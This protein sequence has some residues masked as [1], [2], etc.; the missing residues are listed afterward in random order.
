MTILV[1]V[2]ATGALMGHLRQPVDALQA[3]GLVGLATPLILGLLA[4]ARM[5]LFKQADASLRLAASVFSH[6]QNGIL[7]TDAGNCIID[8]NPAFTRITGYPREEVLGQN[9]RLMRS[10]RQDPAFYAGMWEALRIRGTWQGEIWNLRKSGEPYA[11]Q[12]SISAVTDEDGQLQHYVGIFS[13]VTETKVHV[14][15]MERIAFFDPLTGVPNRRLLLDRLSQALAHTQR[16]E[17]LLAVCYLDLDGFKPVNDQFG[18]DAGDQLL[19]EIAARLQ[20]MLR[21]GDT[22]ARLGGDEFV[23][24]LGGLESNDDC[25]NAL[26]RVLE[27]IARPMTISGQPVSVSASIGVTLCPCDAADTGTLLRH[28]DQA[29][30]QA[31]EL[32]RNRFYLYDATHEQESRSRREGL[33]RLTEALE[34]REFVL[35]YQPKVH[36]L[37]GRVTGA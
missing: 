27:A 22:L 7:L 33:K 34:Q 24:L 8:V 4:F 14:A 31:K 11:S 6:S 29:M 23:L 16:S 20:S 37:T 13:D 1:I 30:Y 17:R 10:N 26:E 25:Y 21:A 19:V 18:H 35:H 28:A 9:P 2:V 36:L 32:G 15:E 12:L 5:I 3:W